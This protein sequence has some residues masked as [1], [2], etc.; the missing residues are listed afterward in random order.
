VFRGRWRNLVGGL[1][2][3]NLLLGMSEAWWIDK[4]NRHHGH[5]NQEGLD[6]D[7]DVP[8]IAFSAEQAHRK[9]GVLRFMVTYQRYFY[10]PVTALLGLSPRNLSI[11]YLLQRRAAYPRLEGACLTLHFIL[12]FGL[13]YAVL[14][15]GQGLAFAVV[16]H[17]LAGIYLGSAFA[18]NHKGMPILA[19][20]ADHDFLRRQVLT[21]RN[22]FAH[23]FTD[24]WYGGLNYQIEHHLFP[25]MPRN[26]LRE[27]QRVVR[28]FCAERGIA[29]HETTVWQSYREIFAELDRVSA[30]LR[31]QSPRPLTVDDLSLPRRRTR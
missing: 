16:H 27:A 28:S 31:S 10:L 9:R 23:P 24:F 8:F 14:G 4:H 12:Y 19:D 7:I 22:V 5:P 29:Y 11:R 30:T 13:L 20:E 3:G 18:P 26:R 15:V 1:V 2:L 21:S 25:T 6:P 17:A